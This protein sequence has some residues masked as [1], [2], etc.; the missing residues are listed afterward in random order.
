MIPPPLIPPSQRSLSKFE[1][2]IP[3]T[4][5][6][7]IVAYQTHIFTLTKIKAGRR[8]TQEGDFHRDKFREE[9]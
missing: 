6:E 9:E 4:N 8:A 3:E 2:R 5:P 7:S 1:I